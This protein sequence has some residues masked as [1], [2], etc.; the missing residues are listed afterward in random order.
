MNI[1]YK[2]I[3]NAKDGLSKDEIKTL[4]S[5][6]KPNYCLPPD[7]TDNSK[8]FYRALTTGDHIYSSEDWDILMKWIEDKKK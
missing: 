5:S 4:I 8:A 1:I 3:D 2:A 6:V 7:A